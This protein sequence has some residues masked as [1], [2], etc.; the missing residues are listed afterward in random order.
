V[1]RMTA[2]GL[3]RVARGMARVASAEGFRG[4]AQSLLLRLE[5]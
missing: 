5:G 3:R 4:H 1:V 2:R